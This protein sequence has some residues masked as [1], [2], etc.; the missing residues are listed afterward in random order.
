[1][2][3]ASAQGNLPRAPPGA[4]SDVCDC[5]IFYIKQTLTFR[6]LVGWQCCIISADD[7]AIDCCL[8]SCWILDVSQASYVKILIVS[9]SYFTAAGELICENGWCICS[10]SWHVVL[11]CSATQFSESRI[12]DATTLS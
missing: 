5:L 7:C 11:G 9:L 4:K 8:N 12:R 2:N 6:L 3:R 10:V 1:M